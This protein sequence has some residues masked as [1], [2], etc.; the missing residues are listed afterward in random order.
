MGIP[1][2]M[3]A[4]IY[5]PKICKCGSIIRTLEDKIAN[6]WRLVCKVIDEELDFIKHANMVFFVLNLKVTR[7]ARR[8][9]HV[10]HILIVNKFS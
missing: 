8:I 9:C 10:N 2:F 4:Y 7:T 6:E 5:R 3:D 1:T